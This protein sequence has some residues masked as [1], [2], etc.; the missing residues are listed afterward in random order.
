MRRSR[1]QKPSAKARKFATTVWWLTKPLRIRTDN[2]DDP[3][4]AV[5]SV[6]CGDL[7]IWHTA[8]IKDHRCSP[9]CSKCKALLVSKI[10]LSWQRHVARFESFVHAILMTLLYTKYPGYPKNRPAH[11]WTRQLLEQHLH[12]VL[13]KKF[14][15]SIGSGLTFLVKDGLVIRHDNDLRCS[16]SKSAYREPWYSVNLDHPGM[17]KAEVTMLRLQR[18]A[19]AIAREKHEAKAKKKGA[20]KLVKECPRCYGDGED[21]RS[22]DSSRHTPDECRLCDGTGKVRA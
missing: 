3:P 21:R 14:H 11:T 16:G 2:D 13:P 19:D 5:M 6:Y 17:T 7:L 15:T 8:T 22:D 20:H 10:R 18:D 9:L 12:P 4:V 1:P